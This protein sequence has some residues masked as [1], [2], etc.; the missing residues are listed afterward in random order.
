MARQLKLERPGLS[1]FPQAI[2]SMARVR[3]S[4]Q[5]HLIQAVRVEGS[6][7]WFYHCGRGC[8]VHIGL[9]YHDG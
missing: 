2:R 3:C 6:K 1:W 7:A 9:E 8:G 5:G 4:Q